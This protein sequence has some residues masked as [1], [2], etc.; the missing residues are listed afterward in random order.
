MTEQ[1]L[2]EMASA[3]IESKAELDKIKKRT[4]NLNADI[5]EAMTMLNLD[6]ITFDDGSG[7]H[8]GITTKESLNE[9]ML[10]DKLKKLAPNTECIKTKEYIDMDI[11]ENEIYHDKLPQEAKDAMGDCI[12]VKETQVLTIKKA[13][14]GYKKPDTKELFE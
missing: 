2:R 3:Y 7:V 5:K 8:C 4:D 1:D 9:D 6:D 12:T 11:L 14:K 10:L 13:K